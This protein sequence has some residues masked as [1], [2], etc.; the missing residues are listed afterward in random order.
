MTDDKKPDATPENET[1]SAI[2]DADTSGIKIS[3]TAQ[4]GRV[5]DAKPKAEPEPD[6]DKTG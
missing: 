6:A 4:L 2:L 3:A 5:P 1:M